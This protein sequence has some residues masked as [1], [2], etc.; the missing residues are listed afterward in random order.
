MPIRSS[1]GRAGAYRSLW[2]WPL[3]SPLR[4]AV[5]AVVVLGLAAGATFLG[6]K[7]GGSARSGGLLADGSPP[8]ASAPPGTGQAA[9]PTPTALPPLAPLTPEE[10]PVSAAPPQALQTARAWTAAW[11]NHPPGTTNQQWVAGMRAYTTDEYLGV[12]AAVDPANVPASAVTGAPRAVRV[13]P[14]SVQVEVPTDAL[15]LSVLVVDTGGGWRVSG[16]DRA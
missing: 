9:V 6:N 12:L 16:Y 4:L 8:P 14:R 5:V 2:Q 13:S 11:V 15:R 3:R 1:R 10:L 7:V